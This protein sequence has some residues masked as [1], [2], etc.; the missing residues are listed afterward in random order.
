M[1]T[2]T[3][4]RLVE[5][6]AKLAKSFKDERLLN[7]VDEAGSIALWK[8]LNPHLTQHDLAD[9]TGVSQP[10][11]SNRV[12]LLQLPADVIELVQRGAIHYADARDELLPLLDDPVELRIIAHALTRPA[13]HM[14]RKNEWN[15]PAWLFNEL[16]DEFD[17]TLDV[18]ASRANAKC[19]RFISRYEDALTQEWVGSCWLNPPHER[20]LS[21]WIIKAS[22]TAQRGNT[23]VCLLP[24]RSD[25]AWWHA[26]VQPFSEVRFVRGRLRYRGDRGPVLPLPSAVV[27]FRP[28]T[29]TAAVPPNRT[30]TVPDAQRRED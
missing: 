7:A 17:F 4:D 25:T 9:R 1:T 12:R 11:I 8:A 26:Y 2:H 22:E 28:G 3:V 30:Y 15:T 21:A 23:V 14:S 10:F 18:A 16:N 19:A 29:R 6:E 13:Y 24:V 20:D 5:I 27:V